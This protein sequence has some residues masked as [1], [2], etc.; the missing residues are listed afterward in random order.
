[1]KNYNSTYPIF[2][3]RLRNLELFMNRELIFENHSQKTVTI[4]HKFIYEIESIRDLLVKNP[5]LN[6]LNLG[7]QIN[8]LHLLDPTA[9]ILNLVINLNDN[10][11]RDR[12]SKLTILVPMKNKFSTIIQGDALKNNL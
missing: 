8:E 11:R 1:M 4:L 9:D 2:D 12:I 5:S 6:A 10:P 3:D 7:F